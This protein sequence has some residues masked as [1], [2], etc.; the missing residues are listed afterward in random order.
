MVYGW[1]VNKLGNTFKIYIRFTEFIEFEEFMLMCGKQN[2]FSCSQKLSNFYDSFQLALKR[3][4]KHLG[5]K[6]NSVA[7]DKAC[8]KDINNHGGI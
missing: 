3:G 8:F 7:D 5:Y 4:Q 6:T 1:D 2:L